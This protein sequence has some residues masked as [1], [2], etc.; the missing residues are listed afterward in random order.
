MI[1]Y[2]MPNEIPNENTG[3]NDILLPQHVL[4]ENEHTYHVNCKKILTL[5][6]SDNTFSMACNQAKTEQKNIGSLITN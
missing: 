1:D 4:E 2:H 5:T 3:S 6:N